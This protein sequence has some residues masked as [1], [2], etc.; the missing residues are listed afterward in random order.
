MRININDCESINIDDIEIDYQ[1]TPIEGKNY[2]NWN[3]INHFCKGYIILEELD[4]E[5]S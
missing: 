3:K 1:T 2:I 4:N 5:N